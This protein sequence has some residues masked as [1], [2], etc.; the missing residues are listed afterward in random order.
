MKIVKG[1][2]NCRGNIAIRVE[3]QELSLDLYTKKNKCAASARN[4]SAPRIDENCVSTRLEVVRVFIGSNLQ[5]IG[6]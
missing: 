1:I 6:H 3:N 5:I 4:A 2:S